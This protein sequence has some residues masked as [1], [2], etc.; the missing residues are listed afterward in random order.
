MPLALRAR[1][2]SEISHRRSIAD[3]LRTLI[4]EGLGQ[5]APTD[6]RV[7]P[8]RRVLS[9]AR[10]ELEQLADALVKPGP[11]SP[12]GVAQAW[13]LLTDGTGPL[14]GPEGAASARASALSAAEELATLSWTA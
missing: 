11:V 2:L 10:P 14:Y 4:V 12:R 13:L 3:G 1:R 5:H 6:P 7:F 8:D 9:A